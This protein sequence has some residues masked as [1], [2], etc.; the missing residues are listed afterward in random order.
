LAKKSIAQ[1][2]IEYLV[3]IAIVI[4]ISLVVVGLLVGFLDSGG[5][6]GVQSGRISVMTASIGITESLV[7]PVD[8]NFVVRLVNNTGDVLTISGV[9]VGGEEVLFSEDL[10][11]SGSKYFRVET[12]NVCEEGKI[13][14]EDVVISYVTRH[15]LVKTERYPSKV[16]F[17]CTPYNVNVNMLANQCPTVNPGYYVLGTGQTTCYDTSGTPRA[18]A[19][20]GED[21]DAYG[22][23]FA[24]DWVDEGCGTGTVLD[25]STGLCWQKADNGSNV[26]WQTAL[27]YCN[28]NTP[29]LPGTG[30]RLPNVLEIGMMFNY[31]TGSRYSEFSGGSSHWSSTSYPSYPLFA[32][33]LLSGG[34]IGLV[35]K[36]NVG[37]R[38]RCVRFES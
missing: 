2:T 11:H 12:N 5:D 35:D 36:G 22:A 9:S 37:G 15:G 30:W 32:Y 8:G 14:Q 31:Q 26:L 13:V 25:E 3:I 4:V 28:N 6:V 24:R 7:D 29:G 18:C 20:T 23:S 1:G 33:Y 27:D 19:G 10:A 17:D 38:A 21:G 34:S 16:F